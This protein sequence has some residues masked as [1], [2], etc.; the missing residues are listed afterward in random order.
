V[1]LGSGIAS[2]QAQMP[3]PKDMFGVPLPATDVPTGTISVR[4]IRGTFAN[5]VPNQPVEFVVDGK[6]RTITTGADGRAQIAG[7]AVGAKVQISTVVKGERLESQPLTIAASGIRMILVA[8]DPDADARDAE[9]KRLAAA[10]PEKG[11]V[12]FG[13][14]T[15]VIVEL[16]EDTLSVFYVLD[17]QNDARTPVDIGGPLLIDLPGEARGAGVLDGSSPQAKANGPHI[18][19]LGPFAPGS[20]MVRVGYE[21]PFS[22]SSVRLEQRWPAALPAVSVLTQ[23]IGNLD[24][25]SSQVATRRDVASDSGQPLRLLEGPAM[26]AGQ[27]LTLDFSGLPHRPLW[28]RYVALSLA[29]IVSCWGL[30]AAF[31]KPSPVAA[32]T[33]QAQVKA[34]RDRL[35]NA[36]VSLDR[37]RAAGKVTGAA[38]ATEREALISSLERVYASLDTAAA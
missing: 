32:R 1:W 26:A 17:I 29:L 19:V 3:N 18:R 27:V 10:P 5:D 23:R 22:G 8:K 4:V 7:L 37:R 36:L 15:R 14:Q 12:V 30:W 24:V 2:A 13:P 33:A 9:A 6:S 34:E 11:T 21:L 28:P 35:L 20:T 38:Y 31:Q 16:A 25:Q